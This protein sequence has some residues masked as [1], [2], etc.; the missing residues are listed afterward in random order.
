MKKP[1]GTA[2]YTLSDPR[3]LRCPRCETGLDGHFSL[4]ALGA[5]GAKSS[6]PALEARKKVEAEGRVLSAI[7]ASLAHLRA[8]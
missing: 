7:D 2:I 3:E 6:V 1:S 5:L 4:G 8:P